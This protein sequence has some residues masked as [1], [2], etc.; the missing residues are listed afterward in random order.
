[1]SSGKALQNTLAHLH[2]TSLLVLGQP[3]QHRQGQH[4]ITCS[5]FDRAFRWSE[6]H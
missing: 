6:A 1:M 4:T 2:Q 3:Q 5:R